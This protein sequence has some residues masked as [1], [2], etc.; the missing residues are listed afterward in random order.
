MIKYEEIDHTADVRLRIFGTDIPDLLANA[1]EGMFAV[2]GSADFEEAQ[3]RT[4]H[5]TVPLDPVSGAGGEL[6][7]PHARVERLLWNWLK[8]LLQEFNVAAFY[9]IRFQIEVGMDACR[10][11]IWG[12]SFDPAIHV[13][14]T[15]IK[16]VTLHGLK[17]TRLEASWQAEVIFD[18]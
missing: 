7:L 2:I 10:S 3:V 8:R 6:L 12:G 4:L 5:V 17:V 16:G 9:P 18:V 1:A 11:T 14:E 13:Y 15:E